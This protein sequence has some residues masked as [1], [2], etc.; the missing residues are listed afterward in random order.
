MVFRAEHMH[1]FADQA[2]G[3]DMD[4]SFAVRKDRIRISSVEMPL[5]ACREPWVGKTAV[6]R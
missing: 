1:H 3:L 6:P 2:L 4:L 5:L